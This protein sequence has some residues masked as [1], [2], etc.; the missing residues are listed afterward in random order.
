MKKAVHLLALLVVIALLTGCSPTVIPTAKVTGIKTMAVLG[1]SISQASTT[2]NDLVN[3][4]DN[5]WA[6]GTNT[7]VNSHR[8]RIEAEQGTPVTA[9]NDAVVGAHASDLLAQA[10]TAVTQQ[11]DYVLILMG[12]NDFCAPT[13]E[14]MTDPVLYR[15]QV[16]QTLGLLN[17]NLPAAK[18]FISS[19][20]NPRALYEAN[21]ASTQA[22]QVW[23]YAG[24]CQS[25]LASPTDTSQT[26]GDRREAVV[27]RASAYNSAL[28]AVC[29]AA[30][31]CAYDGGSV[32]AEAYG[33]EDISNLDFFHPSLT[34]QARLASDTWEHGAHALLAG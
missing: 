17:A 9:Y 15:Q 14:A 7:V 30:T 16:A 5:S 18:I 4:P 10:N 23:A 20:P 31:N 19:L 29:D 27:T 24:T 13:V 22:Q 25:L 28:A 33:A 21:R 6:T 2:C 26:A 1:D 12:A 32:F 3:C 11:A 34:G 8:Q